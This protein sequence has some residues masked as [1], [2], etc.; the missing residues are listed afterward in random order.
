MREDFEAAHKILQSV[1]PAKYD[2]IAQ[3]LSSQG[4][5]EQALMVARDSD[6]K[7]DLAIELG[8]LELAHEIIVALPEAEL[9]TTPTQHKWKQLGDLALASCNLTLAA[10]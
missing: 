8:K 10:K 4:F 7:F 2:Q 1:P 3:F 5:K 6:L 9:N